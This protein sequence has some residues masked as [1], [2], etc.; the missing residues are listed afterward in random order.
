MSAYLRLGICLDGWTPP[1]VEDLRARLRG[2]GYALRPLAD[3]AEVPET[4]ARR[5]YPLVRTGVL[6]APGR[7]G[8]VDEQEFVERLF[9]RYWDVADTVMLA[10]RGAEIVGLS[11]LLIEGAQATFGLTV[12][13]PEDRARGLATAMK[14]E[15]LMVA[16]RRGC[17][18]VTTVN[19]RH[20][21]A[22]LAMNAR[23]GFAPV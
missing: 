8:F 3:A 14:A 11:Q 19:H 18:W 16:S 12:V 22:A 1:G 23:L 10:S 13:K 21:D 7:D 15:L 2:S 17:A 5:L 9:P 20:N 4:I 6:E